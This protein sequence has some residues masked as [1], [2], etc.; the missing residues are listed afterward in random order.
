[1]RPFANAGLSPALFTLFGG[2][3][4]NEV[5]EFIE[6]I[7]FVWFGFSTLFFIIGL[8]SFPVP[9]SIR[10]AYIIMIVVSL[11]FL[12]V[13]VMVLYYLREINKKLVRR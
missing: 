6:K 4:M 7:F 2:I 9:E 3:K 5:N 8:S 12:C 11:P 1:M 13:P 10:S